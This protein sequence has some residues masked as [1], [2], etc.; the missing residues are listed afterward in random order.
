[1]LLYGWQASATVV[2]RTPITT[3]AGLIEGPKSIESLL[4]IPDGLELGRYEIFCEVWV[5]RQGRANRFICYYD[6]GSPELLR[7][8]TRAGRK[9]KFVPATRDGKPADVYMLLMVRIDI[10]RQGPL[11]LV[12]PNNGIEHK[13]YGLFYIAPQRYNEFTWSGATRKYQPGVVVMWHKMH[14]DEHGKVIDFSVEN[15]SDAPQSLVKRIEE[16][17]RRMEF[18]PGY[19]EGNPVP[20]L[21]AEPVL[22]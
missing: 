8:V 3:P 11:V 21:Y 5:L 20:M 14:I 15:V 12:L 2:M 16:Q 18:I 17:V 1:M 7:A 4:R 22:Q 10:T 19:F 6:K 13:R 9:A